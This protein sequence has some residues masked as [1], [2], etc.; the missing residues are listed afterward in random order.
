MKSATAIREVA[1]IAET[2]D[3]L[4]TTSQAV[5][6]G[7]PRLSLARLAEA[8][9]LER[10]AHGVYRVRGADSDRLMDLR[11]AWL[12]ADPKRTA[13]ERAADLVHPIVVSHRSAAAVHGIGNMYAERHEMTAP[14]RKQNRRSDVIVHRADVPRS[15]IVIAGG[16]MVTTIERTLADLAR[17]EPELGDVADALADAYRRGAV[18]LEALAPTLDAAARRHGARDGADLLERM[19][20]LRGLDATSALAELARQPDL[21]RLLGAAWAPA[22]QSALQV[23][24]RDAIPSQALRDMFVSSNLAVMQPAM[25][26]ALKSALVPEISSAM[27]EAMGSLALSTDVLADVRS[28]M[29]PMSEAINAS[30]RVDGIARSLTSPALAA[31]TRDR[32]RYDD[33]ARLA[34]QAVAGLPPG[35]VRDG[36]RD[37]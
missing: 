28:A 22:I 15:D 25:L 1:K 5:R 37:E 35:I 29:A 13:A 27:R 2:Q 8:G 33:M 32:G 19:L 21:S 9:D 26:E 17:T 20:E 30:A 12:A 16:M 6:I 18:D 14:V 31:L 23:A 10:L 36:A 34:R 11:A 24:V 3:G 7:V 4:V